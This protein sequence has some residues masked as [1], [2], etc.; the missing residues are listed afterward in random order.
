MSKMTRACQTFGDTSAQELIEYALLA[1]FISIIAIGLI[2]TVA[3]GIKDLYVNIGSQID[4][5][6]N[7]VA[8]FIHERMH[9]ASGAFFVP[10]PLEREQSSETVLEIAPPEVDPQQL[11]RELREKA[12]TEGIAVS[13]SIKIAARMV[14]NLTAD[15]EATITPQDPLDRAVRF[16]ERTA[17]RWSVTPLAGDTLTLT[18]TLTAPVMIDGKETGYEITS[19][20]KTVT[21]KVTRRQRL[22]DVLNWAD[23]NKW[24]LGLLGVWTLAFVGWV[25]KRPGWMRKRLANLRKL[26]SGKPPSEAKKLRNTKT[27]GG[28]KRG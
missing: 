21:V 18:A 28:K 26:F 13:E 15:R 22:N 5:A 25:R 7:P 19:F 14:A 8:L 17:W 11:E 10:S 4:D 24:F 9:P 2:T 20:K 6:N 12:K 1:G 3:T 23:K 27:K 16:G